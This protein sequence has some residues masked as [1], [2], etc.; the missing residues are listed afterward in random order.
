MDVRINA[1][2]YAIPGLWKDFAW[3]YTLIDF[4]PGTSDEPLTVAQSLQNIDGIVIVTTEIKNR[5]NKIFQVKNRASAREYEIFCEIRNLVAAKTKHIRSIAKAIASI[6]ALLALA[7]TSLEND[8][9][10]PTL[11]PIKNLSQEKSTTIIAGRNGFKRK[12]Y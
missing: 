5:E 11:I 3:S 2:K 4:P 9:V 12:R 6:D 7:I 1:H 8:F 10:K